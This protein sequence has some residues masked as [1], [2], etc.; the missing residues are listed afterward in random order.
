MLYLNITG[1]NGNEC[2]E[3]SWDRYVNIDNTGYAAMSTTS[4]KNANNTF[5]TASALY[6]AAI[7]D[8]ET[9]EEMPSLA[10]EL[11]LSATTFDEAFEAWDIIEDNQGEEYRP[12]IG[13]LFEKALSLMKT[14]DDLYRI[15]DLQDNF[16][17]SAHEVWVYEVFLDSVRNASDTLEVYTRLLREGSYMESRRQILHMEPLFALVFKKIREFSDEAFDQQEQ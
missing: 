2:H 15:L 17:G 16:L 4:N 13:E 10:R 1:T 14:L 8:V 6:Y 5:K 3:I 12:N 7:M 11:L 9:S